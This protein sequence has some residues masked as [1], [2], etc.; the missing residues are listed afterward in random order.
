MLIKKEVTHGSQH[1]TPNTQHPNQLLMIN[2]SGILTGDIEGD[3]NV[4]LAPVKGPDLRRELSRKYFAKKPLKFLLKFLL[5]WSLIGSGW[6]AFII[7]A[8]VLVL[9]SAFLINGLMYAHLIEL[10]HECL[11]GH[12]FKSTSLNRIFGV[13]C[14]VFMM[15]SHSHYRYDHLRHHAYLGTVKNK[16]HF[17]YRFQNLESIFGF[18]RSF[19]DL[20]RYI[21]IADILVR[22]IKRQPIP[23]VDKASYNR[24]I[25]QEYILYAAIIFGSIAWSIWAESYLVLLAWFLPSLFISEGVHFMIEMPEH[26]G[27][28]TQTEPNILSN[29]RSIRTSPIISWFVNGN[30][31]HTAHHFHQ[32]V[33]MCNVHLVHQLI[34]DKI[35]VIE[36]SYLNFYRKVIRG[37]IKQQ[38]VETCMTR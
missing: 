9:L 37:E 19:F 26:F 17:N 32:G 6:I 34:S 21:S 20:S 13:A 1:P 15:S 29:T 7:G 3:V 24:Q 11:H 18:A 33:P 14:G 27:L 12:A 2:Q 10:Q 4:Q 5:A 36:S 22:V 16:E 35:T 38:L 8:P 30:D 25:K 31:L 23:G 28:N